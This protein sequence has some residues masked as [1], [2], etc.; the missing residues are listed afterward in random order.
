M[1]KQR[2]QQLSLIAV[3]AGALAL[4]A[5]GKDERSHRATDLDATDHHEHAAA[6][7]HRRLR[8]RQLRSPWPRSTSAV[9]S[10]PTSA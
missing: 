8:P 9:R 6:G 1:T 3:M 2:S 5:C 7:R 10:V 4:S